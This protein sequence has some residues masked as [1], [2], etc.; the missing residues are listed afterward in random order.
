MLLRPATLEDCDLLAELHA[1]CFADR[2]DAKSFRTLLDSGKVT[3][4][5]ADCDDRPSGFIVVRSAADEAEI[6]TFAVITDARR[7]GVGR[8]LVGVAAALVY[9]GGAK[10]IFLEVR[11]N[12]LPAL[13]LY[14]TLGFRQ[15]GRRQ[16]YYRAQ[17][18]GAED[19]LVLRASLPLTASAWEIDANSTTVAK[20]LRPSAKA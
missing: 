19:G 17:A 2:W 9:Q 6:V 5:I 20:A 7:K 10:A 16:A 13:S 14:E 8:E 11:A 12:N 18:G 15:L 1:D 3:G 4:L